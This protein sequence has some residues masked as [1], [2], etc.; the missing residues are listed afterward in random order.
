MTTSAIRYAV[1]TQV[2]SLAEAASPAWISV[3]EA[4]TIWM[5]RIAMNM[6]NTIDRK[7]MSLR[8]SRRSPVAALGG[9]ASIALAGAALGLAMALGLLPGVQRVIWRWC[10]GRQRSWARRV[11]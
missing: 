1:W 4:E 9:D 3:S 8:G 10:A 7:A 2:I 6:P 5:S 11:Q